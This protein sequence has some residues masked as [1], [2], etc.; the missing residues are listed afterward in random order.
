VPTTGV[1]PIDV[2]GVLAREWRGFER[3]V[4]DP[5][6]PPRSQRQVIRRAWF[7]GAKSMLE[8]VS[9]LGEPSAEC[10]EALAQELGAGRGTA[11]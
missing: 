2:D 8:A 9:I 6:H 5:I 1:A 4:L 10:V 11:A 3:R 7:A